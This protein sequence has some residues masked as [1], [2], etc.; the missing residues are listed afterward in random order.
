[1]SV[2]APV[3]ILASASPRRSQLL[4]QIGVVHRVM[5]ADI[6]ER[7]M[8]GESIEQC[9]QRLSCS[10]ALHIWRQLALGDA[11]QASSQASLPAALPVLG[12]DTVVVIGDDMLGK[13]IDR[14]DGL[15]MLQRLSAC[16][17]QVLSGVALASATGVRY[18]LSRSEVRMRALSAQE[19]AQY[20]D[21]GEPS[22]KAGAYA[23]QGSGAIFV[24]SLTGS[25]SGVMGLP[26]F[27]TAQLLHEAGIQW[28]A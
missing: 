14:D 18:R 21:S 19:C 22:G 8:A 9:V 6:D 3:L 17:H 4:Q 16:S 23:I 10:K 15:Q 12:A 24:Q 26:L 25:Y 11:T 5:P 1:V 20:W 7:R 28:Q 27:E 2:T 13:P